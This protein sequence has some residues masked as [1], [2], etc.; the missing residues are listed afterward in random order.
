[1]KRK[2]L[3]IILSILTL[4]LILFYFCFPRKM[5]FFKNEE[6]DNIQ[7]LI[8]TPTL[9]MDLD[10]NEYKPT[11]DSETYDISINSDEYKSLKDMLVHIKLYPRVKG[12]IA[13][14]INEND[15]DWSIMIYTNGKSAY[16]TSNG[17]ISYE[18]DT[19][20]DIMLY[21]LGMNKENEATKIK[22]YIENIVKE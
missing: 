18:K 14:S 4:I 1:M 9:A 8:A 11:V 13:N 12:I 17:N 2:H 15:F 6:T 3:V 7:I 5:Q 19:S 16:I 21:H 10:T 20:G 22:D